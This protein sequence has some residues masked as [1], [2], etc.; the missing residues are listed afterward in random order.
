MRDAL[1]R[2]HSVTLQGH[3]TSIS[4]ED[5]FWERLR[6]IAVRRRI[7]VNALIAEVDAGRDLNGNLSSALRIHVLDD[8]LASKP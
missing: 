7:S 5:A 8:A 1:N 4:L 3:R 6:A 2:R